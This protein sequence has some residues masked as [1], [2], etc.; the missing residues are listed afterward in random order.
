[1][2]FT[3]SRLG[4]QRGLSNLLPLFQGQ[5]KSLEH[6]L[7]GLVTASLLAVLC[8]EV[9]LLEVVPVCIDKASQ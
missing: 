5:K 7:Q 2:C 1:M 4:K 9:K 8:T 6:D 3:V